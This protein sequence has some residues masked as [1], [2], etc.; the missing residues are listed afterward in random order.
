[1]ELC[2]DLAAQG[3]TP[4]D[5]LLADCVR[6]LAIPVWAMVRPR[7]GSFVYTPTEVTTMREQVRRA[8]GLGARGIVTGCLTADGTVDAEATRA[9]VDAAGPLPVTFHRAFDLIGDRS[10]ALDT[11]IALGIARILTSGGAA[12]AL[13]GVDEIASL[14]RRAA[15]RLVVMAG[16]GIR[17]HNVGQVVTRSGVTE[18]HA[19]VTTVEDV[20]RLVRGATAPP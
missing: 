9:V 1:V 17:W 13:E 2:V 10:G 7:G 18:V 14:V 16:G 15:G 5:A 12:T 8:R 6:V 19:H 3:I 11:L 20:A 4:P